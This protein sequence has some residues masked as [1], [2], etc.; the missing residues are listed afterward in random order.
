MRPEPIVWAIGEADCQ[1]AVRRYSGRLAILACLEDDL[2]DAYNWNHNGRYGESGGFF[3]TTTTKPPVPTAG[4]AEQI[5]SLKDELIK[6]RAEIA[7]KWKIGNRL[8]P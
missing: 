1:E 3:S 4:I 6:E 5:A 8:A 2:Y 7:K